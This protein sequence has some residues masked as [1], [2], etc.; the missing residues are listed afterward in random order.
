MF[1]GRVNDFVTTG[2]NQVI[3][4]VKEINSN[5][6]T[7][8]QLGVISLKKAGIYNID[9]SLTVEGAA[10]D[11]TIT[12]YADGVPTSNV[13]TV[14]VTADTP[15][16]ISITDAVKVA[17]AEFPEY[18]NISLVVAETGVTVNGKIRVEYLQ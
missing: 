13:I 1:L 3:P 12:V 10:G 17:R 15:V 14:T 4:F 6:K 11:V 16:S 9:A 8:N 7:S 2:V 5:A 18:A